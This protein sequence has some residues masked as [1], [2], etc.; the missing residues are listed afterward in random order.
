MGVIHLGTNLPDVIQKLK[1][2]KID[3]EGDDE[4]DIDNRGSGWLY[5]VDLD[6]E[7]RFKSTQPPVLLEIVAEDEHIRLGPLP[8]IGER[9]HKI[10]EQLQV[11]DTETI[12]RIENDDDERS[13]DGSQPIVTDEILLR[14]G[15]LWIPSLGLGLSMLRGE[16]TT[17]RLRKPE[18]SPR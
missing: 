18:E 8:V 1:D 6:T 3:L 17:V 10:V 14:N 15:T 4:L 2:A 9:L 11:P 12:W 13:T 16:I 7:L 5:V